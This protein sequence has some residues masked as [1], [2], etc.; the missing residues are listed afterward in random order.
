MRMR[1]PVT[2]AVYFK[3]IDPVTLV[4]SKGIF[5]TCSSMAIVIANVCIGHLVS[6]PLASDAK[7]ITDIYV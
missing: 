7:F 1:R 4:V 2:S 3:R 5:L 6:E